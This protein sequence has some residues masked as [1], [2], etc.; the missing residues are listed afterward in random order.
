MA[1]QGHSAPAVATSLI[2]NYIT[3]NPASSTSAFAG[4]FGRASEYG[5][6]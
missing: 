5:V 4:D 2:I 3:V 6:P 1:S